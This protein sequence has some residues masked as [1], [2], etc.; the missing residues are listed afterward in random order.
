RSPPA[1]GR[2]LKRPSRP[3]S[4]MCIPSPPPRGR[5][6][7]LESDCRAGSKAGVAPRVKRHQKLTP[8]RQLELT[9]LGL[10]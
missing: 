3:T 4:H 5:G 9:P 10:G 2:G 7:K 1:R 8:W 6:L